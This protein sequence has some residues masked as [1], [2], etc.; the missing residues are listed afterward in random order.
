MDAFEQNSRA[1]IELCKGKQY[2]E[3]LARFDVA[4]SIRPESA[5]ARAYRAFCNFRLGSV[6]NAISDAKLAAES[7]REDQ[8]PN[9]MLGYL[10]RCTGRV[11]DAVAPLARALELNPHNPMYLI[12]LAECRLAL[13]EDKEA[14][15]LAMEAVLL[16]PKSE[17]ARDIASRASQP[18]RV[19]SASEMARAA[20]H[21]ARLAGG[22]G[23]G[24]RS[25]ATGVQRADFNAILETLEIDP[26]NKTARSMAKRTLGQAS[27]QWGLLR[28]YLASLRLPFGRWACLAAIAIGMSL[29]HV[30][31]S[32]VRRWLSV[33]TALAGV[34]ALFYLSKPAFFISSGFSSKMAHSTLARIW[35]GISD[36]LF[37]LSV[38][39]LVFSAAQLSL[40]GV[41]WSL[42]AMAPLI[43]TTAVRAIQLRPSKKLRGEE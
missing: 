16:D 38:V 34:G 10:L 17:S 5:H 21:Q 19:K 27:V 6:E 29:T 30:G 2:A 36:V 32:G 33:P 24:T 42:A 12:E 25:D 43:V 7:G 4:L 23:S 9:Y 26:S 15:R 31:P 35:A 13:G 37:E 40:Q 28:V 1:G 3:A 41:L 14:A 20:R 39:G 18:V 11:S 8:F 22:M